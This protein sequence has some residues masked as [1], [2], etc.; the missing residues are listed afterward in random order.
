MMSSCETLKYLGRREG[1]HQLAEVVKFAG[2]GDV[3]HQSNCT[4]RA[5]I[6]S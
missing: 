3:P 4:R 5:R 2:V 1:E 6:I